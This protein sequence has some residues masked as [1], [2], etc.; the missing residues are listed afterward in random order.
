MTVQQISE[1]ME[2]GKFYRNGARLIFRITTL[3]ESRVVYE[4]YGTT[5][6]TGRT[7]AMSRSVFAALVKNHHMAE[8]TFKYDPATGRWKE[9]TDYVLE[10]KYEFNRNMKK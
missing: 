3:N 4:E 9:A 5:G 6:A 1:R 7:L 8:T 2:V 10:A